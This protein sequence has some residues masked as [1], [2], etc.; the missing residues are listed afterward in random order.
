MTR[1]I[2]IVEGKTEEGF[3][4][5]ILAPHLSSFDVFAT[6]TMM[7]GARTRSD[8]GG[9]R[10]WQGVLM[11]ICDFLRQDR[12][13]VVSTM[14]DYYGMP[15]DWPGRAAVPPSGATPSQ[16]A[17]PIERGMWDAVVSEMGSGFDA[18]RFV[19]YVMMHEFEAMLFSDCNGL[20]VGIRQPALAQDLQTVRDEFATP[21]AIDDSPD[22]APSKRIERLFPGYRKRLMGTA[23][24]RAIGLEAIREECPHFAEWMGRLEWPGER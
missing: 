8:R 1:L 21:E 2:V 20:A 18:S 17:E 9:V 3:V 23:A 22:S 7:G 15:R 14:V 11:K 5:E 10:P 12:S 16:I 4:K 13:L 19:P 6:A 24:A